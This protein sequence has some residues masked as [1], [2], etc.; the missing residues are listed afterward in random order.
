[1]TPYPVEDL[2]LMRAIRGEASDQ[3]ELYIAYPSRDDGTWILVTG[4]PLRDEHGRSAGRGRR[5]PRHHPAQESR[6][7]AGGPVRDDPRPGR[8]RLAQPSP[9]SRSWKPSA[10]D[11][12][13]DFGAFWRVESH[14]QRLRCATLVARPTASVDRVRGPDSRTLRPT[15]AASGCR[16]ASGQTASPPGFRRWPA[17][18]T[19]PRR[20]AAREDG[21][22]AAFAV[23]IVLRGECLGVLEFFSHEA[24]PPDL[25]ILEMMNS[26]GT[27]IGQFIERH[28]MRARVIQSEKL[29][30]L[31]MLSA[32][33][34]HE[35]NNPLAYV[36]NN[37][38][39]L[40]RDV[41]FLLTLLAIYEKA[42]AGPG[43]DAARAGRPGRPARRRS[44]TWI[45]SRRTWARSCG[46]R[47]KG[48]S[49]WPTSCRTSA[50]SPASTSAAVDQADIH[51]ALRTAVEMVRGRL[52]RRQ[53]TVEEQLGELPL[54]A[55][56]PAQLNQVFL[57]LLVNAMQAIESTH[58]D[59][60][61]IAITTEAA[62]GEVIVEVADNGCGIPDE[63][64]P[65]IF[66][67]FFTTKGVG[68]G[69]G[70]GL[71]ITHSMVQDH[72]GR[73]EV[74]SVLGQGTRFRVFLP[75]VSG[76]VAKHSGI[77]AASGDILN[78]RKT[79]KTVMERTRPVSQKL[80]GKENGRIVSLTLSMIAVLA[81]VSR[82]ANGQEARP[83]TRAP[84]GRQ[85]GAPCAAARFAALPRIRRARR[86]R[87]SLA[88]VGG[89]QASGQ[90]KTGGP[91]RRPA[92]SRR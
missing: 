23:P 32:G 68:D 79:R 11:S 4:R 90:H 25:A 17:T 45:T 63:I 33:V 77:S 22:H 39:V 1:M 76:D 78:G 10:S 48:S 89:L 2:P 34:A 42:G 21:L 14:I 13:W 58:R 5:L 57:N 62:N 28:Q 92:A 60:G 86:P 70:L 47:G 9:M 59:D 35:I 66:D 38:A 52:D 53:I 65:Q 20:S 83:G 46:A 49:G 80:P 64:L 87:R 69:T 72:G 67:P 27:Q 54:V 29:A 36:A 19:S 73:L 88:T 91:S 18:P 51:E 16:A 7:Q 26:L 43:G 74:E 50:D 56:S 61:R 8:G 30:S 37:L 3:A 15:S 12:D 6:A 41:R 44:S 75:A 81:L 82:P 55:G 85:P 31:G 40:E 84:E 71:S 24:R